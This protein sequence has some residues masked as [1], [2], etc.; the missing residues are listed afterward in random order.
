[1]IRKDVT[2][3]ESSVDDGRLLLVIRSS[4]SVLRPH[5][6]WR[7]HGGNCSRFFQEFLRRESGGIRSPCEFLQLSMEIKARFV[8]PVV[9]VRHRNVRSG[10]KGRHL[11]IENE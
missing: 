1:M 10:G 2:R 7:S 11:E 4:S 6:R 3:Q 8:Q 5:L 9:T